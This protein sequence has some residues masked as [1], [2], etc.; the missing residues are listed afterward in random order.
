MDIIGIILFLLKLIV[1]L[2]VILGLVWLFLP[3]IFRFFVAPNFDGSY[4]Y[5][6]KDFKKMAEFSVPP[7]N[8]DFT[9]EFDEKKQTYSIRFG[10]QRI[11]SNGFVRIRHNGQWF[12][13][14]KN[15]V[16]VKRNE[17]KLV[18]KEFREEQPNSQLLGNLQGAGDL[19]RFCAKW[20]LESAESEKPGVPPKIFTYFNLFKNTK[21][22]IEEP[23][24]M[25]NNSENKEIV[26]NL[27]FIIFEIKFEN[28]LTKCNNKNFDEPIFEFPAFENQSPN[29]RYF[30]YKNGIFTPPTR[31]IKSTNAPRIFFDDELN[32]FLIT[33]MD[34][35]TI[36]INV[37]EDKD[38]IK[39]IAFGLNGEIENIPNGY[40]SYCLLLFNKGIRDTFE[41]M[42]EIL[43]KFHNK[44]RKSMYMDDIL[45]YLGYWTDNG[46]YYYYNPLKNKTLSE[47]LIEVKKHMNE[48]GLLIKYYNIDSWWYIKEVAA[49]KRKILGNLGRLLGGG[50]YGGTIAWEPDPYYMHIDVAELSKELNAPFVA[51]NRWFSNKTVYKRDFNFYD[52]D[53]RS[54]CIDEEFW[55]MIMENCKKWN[56]IT[57]EQDWMHNQFKSFKFLRNNVGSAD[58]WLQTM[59]NSAKKYNRTIQ[60]CMSNPGM[61]LTSIK[62]DNV[63]FARTSGDYHPRWPRIYDYRFFSQTN[64]LAYALRLWPF[65]DVFRSQCEGPINGEKQPEFM[66]LI[67]TL[68]CGPVGIG[69]KIGKVGVDILRKTCRRDGLLLKPDKSLRIADIMFIPHD[70]Y[71]ISYTYSDLSDNRWFYV[72]INKLKIKQPKDKTFKL[73]DIDANDIRAND[74][75]AYSYFDQ[76]IFLINKENH[77]SFKLK[78]QQYKYLILAP[79][80]EEGFAIIGDVSKFVPIN[81]KTFRN[82]QINRTEHKYVLKLENITNETMKLCFYNKNN[83]KIKKITIEGKIVFEANFKDSIDNPNIATK[84]IECHYISLNNDLYYLNINFEKEE[85]KEIEIQL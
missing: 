32:S 1:G 63:S 43:R 16:A 77:L 5:N 61:F 39:K 13:S 34:D 8:N 44:S 31:E 84:V 74:Y 56:I 49:W 38:N 81:F 22:E 35:F 47:T 11:L 73:Q 23:D 6:R 36:H 17:K 14:S 4:K 71:Y 76:K 19:K 29:K 30:T 24:L 48:L 45:S 83:N 20:E 2:T 21:F 40:S 42:G 85:T 9:F 55:D 27:N 18:L 60:Y 46:A 64:I 12:S 51:H 69:D 58:K 37:C 78:K 72:L 3:S 53:G 33:S 82:L 52:E 67:S 66:A 26:K 7:Q 50:L 15:K 41:K 70:K 62:F 28:G 79:I 57:Y 54:I 25:L 68:S 59:A 65:K 80:L 10:D 75:V